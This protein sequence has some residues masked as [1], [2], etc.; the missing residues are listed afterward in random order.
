MVGIGALRRAS[1]LSFI[2]GLGVAAGLAAKRPQGGAV[3]GVIRAPELTT[4]PPPMTSPYARPRYRP[5][6]RPQ[7]VAG[8]AE[9]VVVYLESPTVHASPSPPVVR[10]SQRNRTIIPHV[11]VVQVGTRVEFPNEDDVFHNI[12]SLSGPHRFN[13]GR[14]PPGGSKAEVFNKPGVVRLFCDIHSEMGGIIVVLDTP[15][16]AH[17]DA[18]GRFRIE[19]V[20][21]GQYTLVAWQEAAGTDSARVTVTEGGEST[22]DLSFGR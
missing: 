16:F 13:L 14:Y 21:P 6:A 20:P 9:S 19:G 4:A 5:P 2:A 11:T 8:S 18:D 10:I 1:A 17:P 12:F 22:V 3:T 15:Y 7:A